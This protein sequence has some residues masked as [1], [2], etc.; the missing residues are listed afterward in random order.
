MPF[1]SYDNVPGK[2][3]YRY[4]EILLIFHKQQQQKK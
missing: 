3:K 2:K 4:L 1:N